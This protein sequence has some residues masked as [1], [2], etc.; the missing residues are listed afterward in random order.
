[1]VGFRNVVGD[2][3]ITGW[4]SSSSQQIAFSRGSLGFVAINNADAEWSETFS[5]GLPGGSYCNVFEGMPYMGTCG[6]EVFRISNDG[7]L[8]V[9]IGRRLAIAVH[10]GARVS[11]VSSPAQK[12]AQQVSILFSET[13]NTTYGENIFVVGSAPQLGNWD[14]S[15]AIPLDPTDYPVWG[16]TVYLPPSTAFEYKFIRKQPN[17]NVVWESDPARE[18]TTPASGL[19][20]IETSWR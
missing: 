5:T 4:V 7:S 16:A 11:G 13:A 8:N 14:P 15:N 20:W 1:M 3:P 17:G 18:D 6:G 10:M 12:S 2:A 19:Q 9:T